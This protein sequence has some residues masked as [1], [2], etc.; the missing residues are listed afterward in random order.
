MKT[1]PRTLFPPDCPLEHRCCPSCR[2][3]LP[4]RRLVSTSAQLLAGPARCSLS[5]NMRPEAWGGHWALQT[6]CLGAAVQASSNAA[7]QLPC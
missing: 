7:L 3:R 2:P 1:M 4:K 5:V 6:A